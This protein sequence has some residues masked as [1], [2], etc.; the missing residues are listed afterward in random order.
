MCKKN[1]TNRGMCHL[2]IRGRNTER[3]RERE[4]E[5]ERERKKARDRGE[6]W[7]EKKSRKMYTKI[8]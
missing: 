5:K 4:R 1:K 6:N 2:S 7:N 8:I 3:E